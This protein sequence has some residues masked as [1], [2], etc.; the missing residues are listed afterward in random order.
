MLNYKFAMALAIAVVMAALY[1][2]SGSSDSVRKERDEALARAAAA[3]AAQAAAEAA[4]MAAQAAQA[5]AEANAADAAAA[6]MVAEAAQAAAE[7]AQA[8]AEAAQAAAEAAQMAAEGERDA[9]VAAR[10]MALH[11]QGVAEG[12][13][14]AAEMAQADAE[15]AQAAAEAAQMAAEAAQAMEAEARAAAE[16]AQADAEAAQAAA[17]MA[18]ADA[19]AAQATAEAAQMAAEAAQAAAEADA[20]EKTAAAEAAMAAQMAAETAQAEAEAARDAAVAAQMAAEAAQMTAEA[21]RDDAVERANMATGD[22]ADAVAARDAALAAQA[23]AEAAQMAAEAAQ[24]AAEAAQM[25]AEAA[26]MTAESERDAAVA[27]RDMALQDLGAANAALEKANMDLAT[28]NANLQQANMDLAT[29]NAEI[30]SLKDQLAEKTA[31]EQAKESSAMA[32]ALLARV[33][34]TEAADGTLTEGQTEVGA[35]A[36]NGVELATAPTVEASRTDGDVTVLVN[37]TDNS[38]GERESTYKDSA[39]MTADT[40]A[41]A[42]WSH[43][44]VVDNNRTTTT[45]NDDEAVTIYTNIGDKIDRALLVVENAAVNNNVRDNFFGLDVADADNGAADFKKNARTTNWPSAPAD[46][47]QTNSVVLGALQTI[48]GTT[49]Q[50]LE[51]S[52]T[53]M[54]VPGTFICPTCTDTAGRITVTASTDSDGD[55]AVSVTVPSGAT[56]VFQPDDP[57]VTVKVDDDDY[58]YFGWWKQVSKDT[59]GDFTIGFRTL[60]GGTPVFPAANLTAVEGEAT[61][62]GAAA[63]KYAMESGSRLSPTYEAGIFTATASLTADFGSDTEQLDLSGTIT[64]FRNAAGQSMDWTVELGELSHDGSAA[65]LATD[66]TS[67]RTDNEGEAVWKIGSFSSGAGA[68]DATFYGNSR[69]DGQPGS[70]SGRFNASFDDANAH[71]AGAYG[72]ENVSAD[73]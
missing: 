49:T 20:A 21:E 18:Q 37:A 14:A 10:E 52:G 11:A 2:C 27:A 6:Q 29:A 60:A 41:I 66:L 45:T 54:G 57:K 7:M 19:E 39:A 17:E 42:G 46:T 40:P 16:M 62:E 1:G 34:I 47:T 67:A 69:S 23:T 63:G 8:D 9:A 15:A 65:S 5:A 13:R 51:F 72:A 35:A 33:M 3:E 36:V 38:D 32:Q 58:L 30:E 4:Q 26:Q 56:W 25:A 70:V 50:R 71:I 31:D 12:A 53:W 48:G 59:A 22:A 68:W 61:Y 43:T 28:A 64:N 55:E 73:D 44:V 24:M